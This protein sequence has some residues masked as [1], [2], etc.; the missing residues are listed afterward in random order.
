VSSS[1]RRKHKMFFLSSIIRISSFIQI[2]TG[3]VLRL[4]LKKIVPQKF[5]K[6]C[7]RQ[8]AKLTVL[9]VGMPCAQLHET[10]LISARKLFFGARLFRRAIL[11]KAV[12]ILPCY[13]IGQLIDMILTSRITTS[14]NA[15]A[16]LTDFLVQGVVQASRAKKS[17]TS[18]DALDF[19]VRGSD[20]RLLAG[21]QK[22][23][24]EKI[25]SNEHAH[26]VRFSRTR[27]LNLGRL[28]DIGQ[29]LRLGNRCV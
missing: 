17:D 21:R 2:A 14:R 25:G 27:F 28:G 19:L 18:D 13:Y 1:L 4:F 9:G 7:L 16:T 24:F 22:T 29:Q 3:V 15:V 20:G 12:K 5:G 6:Y 11:F 23:S 8:T 10:I 26:S